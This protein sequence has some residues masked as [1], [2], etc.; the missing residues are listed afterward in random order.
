MF[1]SEHQIFS[2]LGERVDVSVVKRGSGYD[3]TVSTGPIICVSELYLLFTRCSLYCRTDSSGFW[4]VLYPRCLFTNLGAS[5]LKSETGSYTWRTRKDQRKRQTTPDWKMASLISKGTCIW[6]SSSI[7]AKR[8]SARTCRILEVYIEALMRFSHI[9]RL[10]GF[11]Y[12]Q[13]L[14]AVSLGQCLVQGRQA[15]HILRGQGTG[16]GV[17]DW[18]PR[19]I[20]W[21]HWQSFFAWLPPTLGNLQEKC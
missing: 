3:T 5:Q 15:E 21:F 11:K 6:G 10:N 7:A 19:S 20:S 16:W 1:S 2:A 4:G 18:W 13:Y 14:K 8:I 17:F 12:T 9:Y